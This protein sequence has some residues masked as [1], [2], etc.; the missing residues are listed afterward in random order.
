MTLSRGDHIAKLKRDS[1]EPVDP[2]SEAY[3]EYEVEDTAGTTRPDG[4]VVQLIV[5]KKIR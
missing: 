5:A 3:V 2:A 1:Y 4:T